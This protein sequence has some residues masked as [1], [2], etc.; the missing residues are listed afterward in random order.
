MDTAQ[1]HYNTT[2]IISQSSPRRSLTVQAFDGCSGLGSL[3]GLDP[4]LQFAHC[5]SSDGHAMHGTRF[6]HCTAS[7]LHSSLFKFGTVPTGTASHQTATA[8]G[9]CMK[10]RHNSILPAKYYVP[11]SE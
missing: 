9:I 6:Q 11:R 8:D 2:T 10:P 7:V 3:P 1:H 4:L 5:Y